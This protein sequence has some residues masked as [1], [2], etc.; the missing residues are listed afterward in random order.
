MCLGRGQWGSMP[1]H[2]FYYLTT[3]C[4]KCLQ[5]GPSKSKS[6][7]INNI[8]YHHS[9]CPDSWRPAGAS[10]HGL[11][12]NEQTPQNLTV[13]PGLCLLLSLFSVRRDRTKTLGNHIHWETNNWDRN[14]NTKLWSQC[15]YLA[16]S[17]LFSMYSALHVYIYIYIYIIWTH[18]LLIKSVLLC[19][20]SDVTDGGQ[21]RASEH[22]H[23][24]PS[25]HCWLNQQFTPLYSHK[26]LLDSP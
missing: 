12:D 6:I 25:V 21:V 9:S 7:P 17:P 1:L 22:A 24:Q 5:T 4:H 10:S 23:L 2:A 13:H 19:G 16:L 26:K 18:L 3:R 11:W 20:Q 15:F 14:K 8:P